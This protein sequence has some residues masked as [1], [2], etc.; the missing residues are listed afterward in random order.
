MKRIRERFFPQNLHFTETRKRTRAPRPLAAALRFEKK[1]K[2]E[3][4]RERMRARD[5]VSFSLSGDGSDRTSEFRERVRDLS[6]SLR[7][8]TVVASADEDVV[9]DERLRRALNV[10]VQ[11]SASNAVAL[12]KTTSRAMR[13]HQ[14]RAYFNEEDESSSSSSSMVMM[15]L[16]NKRRTEADIEATR[17]AIEREIVECVRECQKHVNRCEE[18]IETYSRTLKLREKMPQFVAH[19]HG[20]ALITSERIEEV[21]KTLDGMR[22]RRFREQA[23]K[24]KRLERR[25]G[26][27][28]RVGVD[29]VAKDLMMRTAT[30]KTTTA[31]RRRV[32]G[33]NERNSDNGVGESSTSSGSQERQQQQQ[34]EFVNDSDALVAEL[35]EVSRGAQRAENKIVEL[36]ALSSMF[37]NVVSKQSQQI[38]QIY[39]EALKTTKFL[40]TGNVEMRKT[41]S[42]R[43]SGSNYMAFVLFIA[44]FAVLFLDWFND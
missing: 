16:K 18:V 17:D 23:E 32:S 21:A 4:E 2:R 3:R 26:G 42:R 8:E 41:I 10:E 29:A 15:M 6:S 35:V 27:D 13:K 39:T 44:T 24:A 40:E 12:A 9:V 22:A 20:I 38:E 1:N 31:V 5:K 28:R 36:S 33:S 43:R 34:Q 7:M 25:R 11:K 30:A 37:A 14:M 19:L